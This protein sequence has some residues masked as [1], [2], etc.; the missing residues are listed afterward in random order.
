MAD[1]R[2]RRK[3][4]TGEDSDESEDEQTGPRKPLTGSDGGEC[5]T[6]N[7][8]E[9]GEEEEEEEDELI[10]MPDGLVLGEDNKPLDDDEDRKNPQYIPKKGTFYEHDDRTAAE[11]D[12]EKP[13]EEPVVKKEVGKKKVWKE[14]DKWNHDKF[15]EFDQSPKSREEIMAIYGYDIRNEGPPKAHCRRRYG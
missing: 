15:N 2:R 14:D 12:V 13:V 8:E 4:D 3:L 6:A 10:I 1:R 9:L 11:D 7:E 5:E